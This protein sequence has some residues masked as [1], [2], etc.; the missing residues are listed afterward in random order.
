MKELTLDFIGLFSTYKLDV[1]ATPKH[2]GMQIAVFCCSK[3]DSSSSLI[4]S[5]D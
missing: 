4:A 1:P 2:F 3:S 5:S